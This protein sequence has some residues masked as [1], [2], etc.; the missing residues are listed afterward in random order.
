VDDKR[1]N[2]GFILPEITAGAGSVIASAK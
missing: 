2:P 1:V